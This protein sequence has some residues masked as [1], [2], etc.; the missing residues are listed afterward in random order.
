MNHT[1]SYNATGISSVNSA[2]ISQPSSA[3]PVHKVNVAS[4]SAGS[5]IL[6]KSVVSSAPLT[7]LS[8]S[9]AGNT[10]GST[11]GPSIALTK[12][13]YESIALVAGFIKCANALGSGELLPPFALVEIEK[14]KNKFENAQHNFK[15][16]HGSSATM[17]NMLQKQI[18]WKYHKGIGY[19]N[20]VNEGTVKPTF[21]SNMLNEEVDK[22]TVWVKE[23][24]THE[25]Q[26]TVVGPTGKVFV[27]NPPP[28][29]NDY[30]FTPETKEEVA[31]AATIK[32]GP[33]VSSNIPT[34]SSARP[35]ESEVHIT[36][37]DCSDSCADKVIIE[38]WDEE[39]D[40]SVKDLNVNTSYNN[41]SNSV[42]CHV[43]K[44]LDFNVLKNYVPF[45]PL[46]FKSDNACVNNV[47]GTCLNSNLSDWDFLHTLNASEST[48][49]SSTTICVVAVDSGDSKIFQNVSEKQ[50]SD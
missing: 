22:P 11:V 36:S 45:V 35:A 47:F 20:R 46:N 40:E 10:F 49:T 32:Y 42:G 2:F 33:Q 38:Y 25:T 17:E 24:K 1:N 50:T 30:V 37:S 3:Y 7:K 5:P 6:S 43:S 13:L 18:K 15:I 9:P 34:S 19:V 26:P 28:L 41:K 31:K 29:S 39:D 27:N 8:D 14:Y 44:P 16:F 48:L 4:L 21:W 23:Q 12:E